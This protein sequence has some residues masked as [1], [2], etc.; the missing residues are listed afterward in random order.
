MGIQF[1]GPFA[2]WSKKVGNVV[3]R[4]RQGRTILA[5]YQP[6]VFNPRTPLQIAARGK[7]AA[8]TRYLSSIAPAIKVGYHDLDGYKTG[9]PFSAAVGYNYK[10]DGITSTSAT[11]DVSVDASK[12]IVSLGKVDLPL[13]PSFNAEGGQVTISYADNSGHGDALASDYICVVV[14]NDTKSE[15]AYYPNVATRAERNAV[16]AMPTS[17]SGDTLHIWVFVYRDSANISTSAY[18]GSL[19]L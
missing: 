3:G 8:L 19:T 4:I 14:H 6:N 1:G 2:N 15:G 18:L 5:I 11:G 17:W 10:L 7:F 12:V 9:N 16:I 13:S